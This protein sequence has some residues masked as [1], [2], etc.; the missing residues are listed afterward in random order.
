MLWNNLYIEYE[1]DETPKPRDKLKLFKACY[2][3]KTP[4]Y[5]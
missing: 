4:L 2:E 5:F 1:Y 3:T